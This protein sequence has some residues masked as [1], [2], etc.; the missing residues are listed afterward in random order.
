[1]KTVCFLLTSL[2]PGGVENYCL[3]FLKFSM[4][5]FTPLIICKSGIGGALEEQYRALGCD[6][7]KLK[8]G[9][10]NVP[11]WLRIYRI[12]RERNV[13]SVCDFTGNFSGVFMVIAKIARIPVRV[14]FYRQSSNHFKSSPFRNTYNKFVNQ[15]VNKYSTHILANSKA[16]LDFFFPD[17][18]KD[19][20][21][22]EVI[23]NGI[24]SVP[25][26]S[27][28]LQK[29]KARAI[30]G[31]PNNAFV[32][33]HTGR[34]NAAKNHETIFKV[35]SELIK[36]DNN[37]WFVFC[38]RNTDDPA[39][40]KA[41]S[42]YGIS[43]KVKILGFRTDI[44]VVLSAFDVFYFPS[45]T[46]GQP[47]SLIEA[48]VVGLP[49]V[50]SNIIPIKETMPEMIQTQLIDPYDVTAAVQKIKEIKYNSSTVNAKFN[51]VK[52]WAIEHFS[53]SFRFKQ[54]LDR[55]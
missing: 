36:S 52:D 46:E 27:Q 18:K 23:Y 29:D 35:A 19:D 7:L 31:I 21:R 1:M 8:V 12:F 39:F 48:A 40:T 17:R 14:S 38:G 43:E 47:N 24:D 45:V 2:E 3:R 32:V 30:L 53:A 10:L 28:C 11:N 49:I 25:F 55:L 50:A 51:L 37:V 20:S 33:G 34:Y 41:L 9:Y 54:F 5:K 42:K 4:G 26:L 15:L 22:F 13:E 44:P 16:G 6:I